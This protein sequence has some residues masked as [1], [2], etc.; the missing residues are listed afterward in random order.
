MKVFL[1]SFLIT[2]LSANAFAE[3]WYESGFIEYFEGYHNIVHENVVLTKPSNVSYIDITEPTT[4]ENYGT[5]KGNMVADAGNVSI[6]N[7]GTIEGVVT[8]PQITWII[9]SEVGINHSF[10]FNSQNFSVI[11]DNIAPGLNFDHRINFNQLSS[12]ENVNSFSIINSAIFI[13]DY[14]DWQNWVAD[15]SLSGVTLIINNPET[16]VSGQVINHVNNRTDIA[17][18]MLNDPEHLYLVD[19]VGQNEVVLNITQ[20]IQNNLVP[21][22]LPVNTTN[23]QNTYRFNPSILMHPMRVIN[24]FTLIDDLF[25]NSESGVGIKPFYIMSDDTNSTGTKLYLNG[26]YD[27]LSYSFA[28]HFNHFN[29]INEFNDFS[30]FVYGGDAN[31][32]KYIDNFWVKGF[33]GDSIISFRTDSIF[34]E[35]NTKNNPT[36]YYVYGGIDGG[37]D[38]NVSEN[39]IIVPLIG[40]TFEQFG[41][42]NFSDNDLNVRIGGNAKYRFDVDG[43]K[44]EYSLSGLVNTNCDL[45]GMA[46]IGFISVADKVGVNLGMDAIKSKDYTAYKI[47]IN[48]KLVF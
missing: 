3:D 20:N 8:A 21:L 29:Y 16:I 9:N 47:S 17:A 46:K 37:Y 32:K 11:V 28:F 41:V 25:A 22:N 43:I 35:G 2:I 42:T 36:G 45:I 34:V 18:V 10:I 7:M 24:N 6:N 27:D 30:G 31:I 12:L 39:I 44:Y 40:A 33:G 48:G 14:T 15:V 4:I 38:Y 1:G 13:D 5:I 19:I 26:K 23:T